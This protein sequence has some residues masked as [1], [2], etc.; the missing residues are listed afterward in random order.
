MG[1]GDV[2]GAGG[3][4]SH[5]TELYNSYHKIL[6]DVRRLLRVDYN[7]LASGRSGGRHRS[8]ESG[9]FSLRDRLFYHRISSLRP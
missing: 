5:I 6:I 2:W 9:V 4:I 1:V 7:R 3:G 8:E